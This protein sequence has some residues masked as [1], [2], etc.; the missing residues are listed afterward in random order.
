MRKSVHWDVGTQARV[1]KIKKHFKKQN[2]SDS[3]IVRKS[4]VMTPFEDMVEWLNRDLGIT[5]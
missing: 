5:K 3:Y 4:V 2:L 1:N